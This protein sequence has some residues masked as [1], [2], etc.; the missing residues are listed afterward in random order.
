MKLFT[1]QVPLCLTLWL[2]A[3]AA[4]AKGTTECLSCHDFGAESPVHPMLSSKHGDKTLEGSPLA[5]DGCVSC[6]GDS[7]AHMKAPLKVS[8]GVSFG[9]RWTASI[10]KQNEPCL[11]CHEKNTAADWMSGTHHQEKLTCI[12]CHDL[13]TDKDPVLHGKMAD[14]C[15]TCHKPQKKGIHQLTA[16]LDKNPPCTDCHNPHAKAVDAQLFV[17]NRSEGCRSCHDLPAMA[18]D[19]KVSD[20]AK[21]YHRTMTQ[22]DKTCLGCHKGIAHM[23]ATGVAAVLALP[24]NSRSIGLFY[25]GQHNLEWLMNEHKGSQNL[26]QGRQCLQCHA[27]EELNMAAT[28]EHNTVAAYRDMDVRIEKKGANMLVTF[29]WEG[30]L[31]DKSLAVMWNDG[32]NED[33]KHVGCW[34]A[35]HS[36]MSGMDRDRGQSTGK[37]LVDSRAQ[38]HRIGVPAQLKTEAELNALM[39]AGDFI[40]VQRV[41]LNEGKK[42]ALENGTLLASLDWE[43]ADAAKVKVSYKD[44]R[45]T[46]TLPHLL[47]PDSNSHNFGIAIHGANGP[48][49]GHWVSLP[50][51]YTAK[52]N[53]VNFV[54]R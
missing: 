40:R 18:T 21:S 5:T 34:A 23:P 28:P 13:H 38:M 30:T 37:Y 4:G 17:E 10:A 11:S 36:D 6:H 33:F 46:V 16:K 2:F 41:T 15:T 20:K 53:E 26:R 12:T 7:S 1:I 25:P 22:P 35:C 39:E 3:A 43:D 31:K 54:G 49:P 51:A 50:L 8:P 47:P 42:P 19:P 48:G 24:G 52:G 32:I 27:G 44:G 29:S 45:W 14:V 9:P